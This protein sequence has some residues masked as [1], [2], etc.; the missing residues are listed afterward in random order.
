V[1]KT[2]AVYALV[3]G[4][5]AAACG[6]D[7]DNGGATGGS[8][9]AAGRGGSAGSAGTSA[10]DG[11]KDATGG[12]G[13]APMMDVRVDTAP[14]GID[15]PP[16]NAPP[17][18]DVRVDTAPPGM[19]ALP[20][21]APPFMDVRVDTA[22][23]GMDVSPDISSDGPQPPVDASSDAATDVTD[24][25][26]GGEP[27]ANVCAPCVPVALCGDDGG[28]CRCPSGYTGDGTIAGTGCTDVNECTAGTHNCLAPG[29]NGVCTNTPGSFSCSC[30]SGYSG[31]GTTGGT[32]C[33]DVDECTAGTSNCVATAAGGV[34]ANSPGSF[35]CSCASGYSGDGTTSGTGC[36]DINE[37]VT[38]THNCLSATN[39]GTCTN[40][41]GTFTCGCAPGWAGDGTTGGTGCTDVNECNGQVTCV[42]PSEGGLCVNSPGGYVCS[43]QAG[44]TGNG[45][46]NGTRCTDIN[47]C[48][49]GLSNCVASGSGGTCTNSVGSFGCGCQAGWTGD[50]RTSG[51]G[52]VDNNECTAGTHNCV[53][54]GAGGVCTNTP[55]GSYTCSCQTGWTGDGTTTGTGCTAQLIPDIL[56]YRFDG[57][58]TTVPNQATSPPMGAATATFVGGQTQ[59]G[60]GKCGGALIGN[61]GSG[62][63]H[64]LSTGWRTALTGTS[65]TIS[66]WSSNI[67]STTNLHYIWGDES[68]DGF[69]CFTGGIA[70][71]GNWIMRGGN[72][73]GT[74]NDVLVTGAASMTASMTTFVYD[75]VAH[76]FRAYLNG[77]LN[78]TVA[79]PTAPAITG[80]ALSAFRVGAYSD[81][82]TGLPNAGLMD[83][84]SLYGRA[85]TEAEIL[86]LW[87]RACFR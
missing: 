85:L 49:E 64:H 75:S 79:Q 66:F 31:D 51:T 38:G 71:P 55:A 62:S 82:T 60:A 87:N 39:H 12:T 81:S 32:G 33:T 78:N 35:S 8:S 70:S 21:N 74:L 26:G 41:A 34:C 48:T 83:E 42:P 18:M 2:W 16:D 50:G 72:T 63:A 57:T 36:T 67:P 47:E 29:A 24:A 10:T 45:L 30:A 84:F 3:V 6:G 54:T 14:P 7:D 69:R 5:V 23:P 40:T 43:C 20:D 28:G 68:A 4:L 9:G 15:A 65:W 37:C 25:R 80:S 52:C 44:Y 1:R 53:A 11:G 58:G 22:P 86:A 76:Q 61:G 73:S 77:V 59:G 17:S 19:D 56:Y 46:P 27:D 13:G